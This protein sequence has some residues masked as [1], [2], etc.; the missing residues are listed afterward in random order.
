MIDH[1]AF[2]DSRLD[3]LLGGDNSLLKNS[4]KSLINDL[5]NNTLADNSDGNTLINDKSKS[6]TQNQRWQ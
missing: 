1:A 5:L 3:T 2:T 4:Q 6:N